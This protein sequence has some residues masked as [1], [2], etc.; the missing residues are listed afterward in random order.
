VECVYSPYE[1][2]S[3]EYIRKNGDRFDFVIISRANVASELIDS[4]KKHAPRA[5]ILFNTIDLHSLREMRAAQLSGEKSDL[6]D[7]R[8]TQDNE[9]RVI[10]K[11]DCTLVVSDAEREFLAGLVPESRIAVVPF[12]AEVSES[13]KPFGERKN[14][15]FLG[16]FMHR[17]N[18]DAVLFFADEIWPRISKRLPEARFIIGG[19]ECPKEIWDL[20]SDTIVVKGFVDDLNDFFGSA[21]LSVAPIRFGAG[22]KGKI[23]SSLGCG[24]PCV[25]TRIA[26]E[27]TGLT[28]GTNL[29]IA[30]SAES[31]ADAVV[32]AYT[33]P[34]LWS[35]LSA[36]GREWI[37]IHFSRKVVAA[38]LLDVFNQI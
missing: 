35:S 5:K 29:L 17:P 14:V 25:A 10:R 26:A 6:L 19:G 28:D 12:P 34:E 32:R 22:I 31:F 7:A 13:Q 37:Q 2:S 30:D 33:S 11:S 8:R 24:T 9:L 27:G 36:R 15:V 4:V 23:L 1:S 16:G 18:F 38:K 21:R 3:E 20:A